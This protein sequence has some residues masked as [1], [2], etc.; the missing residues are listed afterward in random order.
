MRTISLVLALLAS[1]ATP[2]V[3]RP[4]VHPA[5]AERAAAS[6]RFE[7]SFPAS[8][9]AQPITGRVFLAISRDSARPPVANAGSFTN[10]TPLFG[11]DVSALAPGQPAIS[12][13]STAGYPTASLRDIPACDGPWPHPRT[14]IEVR[15]AGQMG[16]RGSVRPPG[17][18]DLLRVFE[19]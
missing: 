12:D 9:H 11:L 10:S 16:L 6:P 17:V 4:A 2:G 18:Q 1:G 13:I 14:S 7:I 19:R 5:P 15:N 8:V 3:S